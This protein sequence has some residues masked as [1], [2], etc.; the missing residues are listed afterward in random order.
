LISSYRALALG[1]EYEI[2]RF[3]YPFPFQFS[4]ELEVIPIWP[5]NPRHI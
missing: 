4:I 2:I 5:Y 3:I 1:F